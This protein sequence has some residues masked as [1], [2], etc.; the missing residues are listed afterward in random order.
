MPEPQS[1][2]YIAPLSDVTVTHVVLP[3]N[4]FF[5]SAG[6]E[7]MNPGISEEFFIPA[8]SARSRIW[9]ILCEYSSLVV[10]A[11]RDPLHPHNFICINRFLSP[12]VRNS[13]LLLK[14]EH[15]KKNFNQNYGRIEIILDVS[16]ALICRGISARRICY[17]MS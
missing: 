1:R 6:S 9:F 16:G 12:D 15:I 2:I 13:P 10:G 11:G 3:P 7:L 17:R 8:E 14:F 5:R 4:T